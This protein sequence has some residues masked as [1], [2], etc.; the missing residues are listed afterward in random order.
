MDHL[1]AMY[2]VCSLTAMPWQINVRGNHRI[3]KYPCN[4]VPCCGL[5]RANRECTERKRLALCTPISNIR[6]GDEASVFPH[7]IHHRAPVP[8]LL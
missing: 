1:K 3:Q 5:T 8:K 7:E 6:H 4:S 2:N